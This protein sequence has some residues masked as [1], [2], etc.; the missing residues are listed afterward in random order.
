MIGHDQPCRAR[1]GDPDHEV[2]QH[3]AELE[4]QAQGFRDLSCPFRTTGTRLIR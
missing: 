4:F 2:G 1:K 3:L